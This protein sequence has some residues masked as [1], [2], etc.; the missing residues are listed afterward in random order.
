MA[1]AVA[2]LGHP[3]LP[4]LPDIIPFPFGR[5]GRR[6]VGMLSFF[7]FFLLKTIL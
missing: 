1:M 6:H 3:F 2:K 7:L 5:R 4:A